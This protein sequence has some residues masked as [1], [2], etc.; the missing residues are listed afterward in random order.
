MYELKKAEEIAQRNFHSVIPHIRACDHKNLGSLEKIWDE[1]LPKK[2]LIISGDGVLITPKN[3]LELIE[4]IKQKYEQITIYTAFDQYRNSDPKVEIKSMKEKIKAGSS[5]F[6]FQ[7][8][9]DKENASH[10]HNR[11]RDTK[12]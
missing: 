3:T 11:I 4:N 5:G 12:Q 2:I 1:N 9:F 10:W 7:P 6:W 8:S